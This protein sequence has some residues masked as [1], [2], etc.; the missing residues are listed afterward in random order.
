[1]SNGQYPPPPPGAAAPKQGL[2]TWAKVLIGCGC[3]AL[4]LGVVAL[5]LLGWG[6]KKVADTVSDP[7]KLAEFIISQNPDLEVVE[8]NKDA[9]TITVR[10]KKTGETTTF[11]YADITEG[12]VSVTGSDGKTATIDGSDV[13]KGGNLNITGPDGEKV[14]VGGGTKIPGWLPLYP[15]ATGET[16]NQGL[17]INDQSSGFATQ[18]TADSVDTVRAWYE[19]HLKS[20]GYSVKSISPTERGTGQQTMIVVEKEKIDLAVVIAASGSDTTVTL[21]YK[22]PK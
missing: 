11:N 14:T 2:P 6:A 7:A 15:N 20:E 18:T 17:E 3:A 8:N 1:M 19:D 9:G 12:K 22:G 4:L 21:T 16:N 5:G 10:D 13:S